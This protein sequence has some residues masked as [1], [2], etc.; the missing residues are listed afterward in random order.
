MCNR[1]SKGPSHQKTAF[2]LTQPPMRTG[3]RA[4]P[5][6]T[7]LSP[8]YVNLRNTRS[9]TIPSSSSSMTSLIPLRVLARLLSVLG[10]CSRSSPDGTGRWIAV[11]NIRHVLDSS[12]VTRLA[13]FFKLPRPKG[14]ITARRSTTRSTKKAAGPQSPVCGGTRYQVPE[15]VLSS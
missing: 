14:L 2:T 5:A 6:R 4:G 7:R 3:V 1:R 15:Y 9:W 11:I 10:G 8:D 13:S 12:S